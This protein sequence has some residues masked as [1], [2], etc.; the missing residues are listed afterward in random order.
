[1]PTRQILLPNED[2]SLSVYE[3]PDGRNWPKP[4]APIRTRNLIA[5]AHVVCDPLGPDIRTI[6]WEATLAYRHVLRCYGLRVAEAMDTAQ[7]GSELAWPQAKELILHSCAQGEA[8]ACGAG[9]DQLDPAT[10]HSLETLI[11]A[12]QEQCE[13]IEKCGGAVILMAS[14][15]LARSA[16]SAD[17]YRRVYGR[18]LSQL[19]ER[20]ILHWL[21]PAFDPALTGYWGHNDLYAAA[22]VCLS[23]IEENA[24]CVDGIKLSLLGGRL[25]I[26][27]RRRLPSGVRM[28]TGDDFNYVDLIRGDDQGHSDALLGIF[29]AIAP[30]ASAALQAL[31]RGNLDQYETILRPTEQLSRVVFEPPTSDYKTGIVFLAWLNGFQ[32]HF[33]MLGG[34]E[35]ARTIVHLSRVFRLASEAGVLID[36]DLACQ[37]M[38]LLLEQSGIH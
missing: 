4:S 18:V 17:D 8:V 22:D 27:M 1:M 15:A 16:Q 24:A 26:A 37:R 14:R 12:Y 36:P 19:R 38:R 7:R 10:I 6:D 31:D 29:D 3:P 11:H 33:R 23:I 35:S 9:T 34:R 21:G 25:E 13:W 32:N 30:V 20:A 28:Y 5:A 2:R